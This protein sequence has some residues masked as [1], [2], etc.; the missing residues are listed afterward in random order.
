MLGCNTK[1]DCLIADVRFA[2]SELGELREDSV[3]IVDYSA[4]NCSELMSKRLNLICASQKPFD[5]LQANYNLAVFQGADQDIYR[6]VRELLWEDLVYRDKLEGL[7]S[8]LNREDYMPAL[9]DQAFQM[10]ENPIQVIDHK[11][12]IIDHRSGGPVKNAVWGTDLK[13]GHH[14]YSSI[15]DSFHEVVHKLMTSRE[16]VWKEIDG[17]RCVMRS[18]MTLG[19][20]GG[21]VAILEQNRKINAEDL[22]VLKVMTD[23]ISV[24]NERQLLDHGKLQ[25]R[26]THFINDLIEGKISSHED[27]KIRMQIQDWVPDPEEK[28]CVLVIYHG[29]NAGNYGEY[30]GNTIAALSPQYKVVEL[31][32]HLLLLVENYMGHEALQGSSLAKL[33]MRYNLLACASDTFEDLLDLNMYYRQ[34]L[35]TAVLRDLVPDKGSICFYSD[36]RSLDLLC[37]ICRTTD[38]ESR[39]HPVIHSIKEYDMENDTQL[40]DT[41]FCYLENNRSIGKASARMFLHKNTV[42]YRINRVKSLFDLNFDNHNDLFHLHFSMKLLQVQQLLAKMT[43]EERQ[44]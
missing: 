26:Y 24:K 34:A 15:D 44:K 28:Y 20:F 14:D 22:T 4:L 13:L 33:V 25:S 32:D 18:V 42:N 10:L 8:C 2:E 43:K 27:L 1:L 5:N 6:R 9:L 11:H 40:F 21:L 38:Y 35:R 12:Y 41:L 7:Y 39:L 23:I 19:Q 16:F 30:I 36:F 29:R 17:E 31:K 37:E 3:Y